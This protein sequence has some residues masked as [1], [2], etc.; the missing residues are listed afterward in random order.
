MYQTAQGVVYASPAVNATT[1]SALH[2]GAGVILNVGHPGG[3]G[4]PLQ[5]TTSPTQS[6]KGK[7]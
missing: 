5:L 4:P 1:P 2:N 7:S 6:L 3:P